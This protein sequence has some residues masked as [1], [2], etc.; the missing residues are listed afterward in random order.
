MA[1]NWGPVTA[2]LKPPLVVAVAQRLLR[3]ATVTYIAVPM[4]VGQ[5]IRNR[6]LHA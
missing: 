2:G 4:K 6:R 5:G 3:D 1:E